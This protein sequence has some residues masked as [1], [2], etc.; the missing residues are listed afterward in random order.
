VWTSAALVGWLVELGIRPGGTVD[1]DLVDVG[2]PGIGI[3]DMPDRVAVVVPGAGVGLFMGEG[4][5]DRPEFTLLIRG[6]Q[7]DH[8]TAERMALTADRLILRAPTPA[9]L[10]DGTYLLNV[11][12]AGG[13]PAPLNQGADG[14][15]TTYQATYLTEISDA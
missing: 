10:P 2:G 7:N 6:P 12:R 3:P 11:N 13:R 1:V 14:G 8:L 5:V 4:Q 15:R 9:L